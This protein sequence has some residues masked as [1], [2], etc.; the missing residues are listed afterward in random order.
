MAGIPEDLLE[1][2][3]QAALAVRK[4]AYA[5]FS[6]FRVGAA[7]VGASGRVYTGVNVENSSYGLTICAERVALF[8]MVTEGERRALAVVVA[9]DTPAPVMPCGACRQVL[10]EFGGPDLRVIAVT[11]QGA[12]REVRLGDLLPEGFRLNPETRQPED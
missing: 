3:V 10:Y 4:R 2:A 11:L 7:V 1:Q 8:R 9:T 12:R 5:P 6:G